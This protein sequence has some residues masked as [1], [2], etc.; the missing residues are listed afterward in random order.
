MS[1]IVGPYRLSPEFSERRKLQLHCNTEAC[2]AKCCSEGCFL[3]IHDARRIIALG[4]AIQPYLVEPYDFSQW[5]ISRP[6][7]ISTPVRHPY[8]PDEQ[9][10]FLMN[11]K[12]CAIHSYALDQ[13]SAV[14]SVKPYFCLMFPLTLVDIDINVNEIAVDPKAYDTCLV[15]AEQEKPMYE[16]LESDLRRVIGDQWYEELKRNLRYEP[17]N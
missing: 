13:G 3:T 7:Y 12:L 17:G 10:W 1:I 8:A 4:D 9:C 5:N 15:E 6:G 2:N 16:I 14:E 11:N